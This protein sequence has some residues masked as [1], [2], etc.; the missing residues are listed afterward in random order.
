MEDYKKKFQESEEKFLKIFEILP[1]VITISDLENYMIV[2]VNENFIILTGLTRKQALNHTT[3]D[4]NLWVDKDDV[5]WVV[6]TIKGKSEIKNMELRFRD[7]NGK[8]LI[9]LLST[10]IIDIEGKQFLV[11]SII[12]I[13]ERKKIEETLK[14]KIEEIE[15]F[16]KLMVGRELKMIELK[17]KIAK[18]E[19]K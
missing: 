7:V 15:K 18:L 17:E 10:K 9:G 5:D 11:S 14:D 19:Q 13:T 6:T 1:N 4:L 16:N 3:F 8:I 2:D 12:D